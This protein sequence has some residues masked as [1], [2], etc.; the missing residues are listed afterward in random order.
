LRKQGYFTLV[1]TVLVAISINF[2]DTVHS[3]VTPPINS[4]QNSLLQFRD[5]I[6]NYFNGCN[7]VEEL[8]KE[9]ERLQRVK[10]LLPVYN[11]T[12][13]ALR[14]A[15]QQQ[16]LK[17]YRVKPLSYINLGDFSQVS[18]HFPEFK[19]RKIYGLIRDG[20]SS[21]VV[22]EINGKPVA[23][24]QS[25]QLCSFGV[26]IGVT[27]APGIIKGRRDGLMRV[28]FIPNWLKVESGNRVVTSGLDRIFPKGVP[29]GRVLKVEKSGL[30]QVATV[31]PY[32]KK[33]VFDY[34][35]A[36]DVDK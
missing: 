14:E 32:V 4:L 17:L 23:L 35:F 21:G 28:H 31:E 11:R 10:A 12:V 30:Y 8:E 7:R 9:V 26:N 29:V 13:K 3:V 16:N 34:L 2:S 25:N 33:V 24:L 36:I 5:G 1:S 6:S 20:K 18:L 19:H 15:K 22:S 27:E